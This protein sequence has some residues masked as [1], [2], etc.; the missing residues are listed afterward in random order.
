[1]KRHSRSRIIWLLAPFVF[2]SGC[3]TTNSVK[4][5]EEPS[6]KIFRDEFPRWH[7]YLTITSEQIQ[8]AS[9]A[10]EC[11]PAEL[12]N[13]RAGHWGTIWE[14]L[15]L[16]IRLPKEVFTNGEPVVACITL[17]NTCQTVRRFEIGPAPEEKDSKITLLRNGERILGGDD[18]KP[19]E[20]FS[21]R[22]NHLRRG[23][24]P[25]S[26]PISPGTQRQFFRD[27]ST[28]FDLSVP[29]FYSAR[30]ERQVHAVDRLPDRP[31]YL[32]A[33]TT[34]VISGTV[35]FRVAD[36]NGEK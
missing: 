4:R 24:A 3:S 11:S 25:G 23:S 34:N 33:L 32:R 22:L 12:N 14:G 17:R 7:Y 20:S 1:M 27:L 10:A 35:T 13:D 29:G 6:G 26:V 18:P 30:A 28:V 19:G 5:S 15:Q 36:S 2:A 8:A 21:E 31:G 16:S 9:Q